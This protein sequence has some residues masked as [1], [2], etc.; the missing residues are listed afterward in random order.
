MAAEQAIAAS[1]NDS[2][3]AEEIY[4][5]IQQYK[6]VTGEI[7]RPATTADMW[8]GGDCSMVAMLTPE[9]RKALEANPRFEWWQVFNFVPAAKM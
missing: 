7:L 3:S 6:P 4:A 9:G 1:G 8:H 2:V 5:K